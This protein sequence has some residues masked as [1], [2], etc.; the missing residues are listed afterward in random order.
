LE[1][2]I[3]R[4]QLKDL[5]LACWQ[6]RSKNYSPGLPGRKTPPESLPRHHPLS[7]ISSSGFFFLALHPR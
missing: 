6:A 7:L 4:R 1:R 5:T 2:S 3:D